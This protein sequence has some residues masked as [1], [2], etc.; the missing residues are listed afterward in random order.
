MNYLNDDLRI[1]EIKELLPPVAL[2]EKFPASHNA[3]ETVAK[4]RTAIHNILRAQDDRLLVVIGPCSIHDT[5]AAKEYAARLLT[6]REELQGELEVVMRVY[7]EK[8]RTTV[9]WKGLI[10][11]PH[12]DGSYDINDGLRI[13]RKLLLDINDSGLPAA[14]EF[15]DMITP[16]YL[17]DLMSWGA[18]GART[19]ESQ[20]H[21]E[22][23]SGLSC[24]VGFKN[25]TDGTI[26]VAIDAINA[27]SAPHCFLSVTKW[28]HSAIV[29]T[30]G[31]DDCHI[32]LR[33]G[34]EPNYSSAHVAEVKAGLSKAGLEPQ[35]M[36]DFS[37]ANSSKQ[38]KKQMEVGTDV[39]RQIAQGEKSIMGVMIESHL[40]EGNQNLESGEP[41]TY[42]KSVT[43]A[44]IGWEDTEVLLR[45]LSNA[46]KARRQ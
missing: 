30:A 4:S 17:A 19:T 31:N 29:N 35:I 43:D 37:H 5:Q 1:N 15:L 33:G 41:L 11:D 40:V 8:P 38:F 9:G 39:C 6:L 22:L 23:A 28:G 16:Q 34:K 45:Q 14:G 18:I 24:P 20:V 25:G 27:A 46:V 7:F 32:I 42:G 12:M 36:I 21:R 26:K 44:C 3:A 10:N 2:L 13:A